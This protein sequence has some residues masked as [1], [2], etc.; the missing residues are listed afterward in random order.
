[1][2]RYVILIIIT[3]L[4]GMSSCSKNPFNYPDTRKQDIHD[5][6]FGVEVNDP[7]RWLEDDNSPETKQWV[8]EQNAI[9]FGYL[10]QIPF[11]NDIENTLKELYNYQRI[12]APVVV[13]N[14]FFYTRNT[15]LQEH[16][17]LYMK[18]GA[19]GPEQLI[20]DPATLSNDKSKALSKYK[21]SD[22]ARYLA[23][24][25]TTAG[26]DWEEIY[27]K[28]LQSGELLPDH[29]T[30]IKFTS[31]SW[32][33]NG[34]YY[35]KFLNPDEK[36]RYTAKN[37]KSA[38]FYHTLGDSQDN[39]TLLFTGEKGKSTFYNTKIVGDKTRYLIIYEAESSF[40]QQ[41][42]I[43]NLTRNGNIF[44]LTNGYNFE[45]DVISCLNDVL[46][47]KTNYNA[48]KYRVVK[49]DLNQRSIGQW[50]DAIPQSDALLEKCYMAGD[51]LIAKYFRNLQ[52]ELLILNIE[53]VKLSKINIPSSGT[54][55]GFEVDKESLSVYFSFTSYTIPARIYKYNLRL[56]ELSLYYTP[57]TPMK[58][59]NVIASLEFCKSK[60][61]TEVPMY[62]IRQKDVRINAQA[63]TLLYGY[64]GFNV[65]NTPAFSPDILTWVKN[66]GIYVNAHIRGGGE[67]GEVW[68]DAGTKQKKQNVFDDFIACAE[69]L[70]DNEYT[71]T[72]KLAVYGGSN[73]GLLVGAVINQRPDLFAAAVPAVGVMDMLRYHKFTIGWAWASDY[74]TSDDDSSMF[75]YLYNYSPLHNIQ[76]DTD[77][78]AI[79]VTTADHDDR[80]VPAHSFKYIATMQEKSAGAKPA[81]I[82]VQKNAGHG[83]NLPIS[84]KIKEKADV[85]A[86]L[87]QNMGENFEIKE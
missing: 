17:L 72:N 19:D 81:F 58:T 50:E 48:P 75:A 3:M 68:H 28:D 41:V 30:D 20:L 62:I 23:Y 64:G 16:A 9:T 10:A 2:K 45:Y 78:P 60:D 27:V 18:K 65:I 82:R 33:N 5:T 85:Y 55:H 63:P 77:Y 59:N 42:Y 36:E 74:G 76:T 29:L 11:R 67:Y 14:T 25:V 79:L 84:V 35:S 26:S 56:N 21:V 24:V 6:Y 57:E 7:Y 38:L 15:G 53:G 52:N 69:Y 47:I 43:K 22:D 86:F 37:E 40:G 87:L 4:I 32:H 54:V 70:I 34:F 31:I 83:A 1:M 39:D 8:K 44:K 80:V 71:N 12:S 51:K 73:G 46:Y 66:G 49:V 61:G 13:K